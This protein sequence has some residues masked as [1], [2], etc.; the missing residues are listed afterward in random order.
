MTDAGDNKQRDAEIAENEQQR[1]VI[2]DVRVSTWA[3]A[4]A[5]LLGII[6]FGWMLLR[7]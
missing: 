6:F 4:I 1:Q 2:S 5:V 7:R 3:V